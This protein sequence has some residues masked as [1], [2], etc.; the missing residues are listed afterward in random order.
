MAQVVIKDHFGHVTP[1]RVEMK[2]NSKP[3]VPRPDTAVS[4]FSEIYISM[5]N[6]MDS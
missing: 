1:N 4:W 6:R 3:G 5:L 2:M